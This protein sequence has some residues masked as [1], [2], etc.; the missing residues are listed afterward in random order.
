[1]PMTAFIGVRISWLIVARKA[2]LA[3]FAS[4]AV[5]RASM[6]WASWRWVSSRAVTSASAIS[7]RPSPMVLSSR[8]VTTWLRAV[9]SPRP[10]VWIWLSSWSTGAT[11]ERTRRR[12]CTVITST[13]PMS[14][15]TS[16]TSATWMTPW[17]CRSRAAR[18][19]SAVSWTSW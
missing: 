1:M 12:R 13:P 6:S 5:R 14:S 4:S 18:R 19:A 7:S 15:S 10:R 2:D 17:R 11:T 16:A 8:G 3:A 9:R